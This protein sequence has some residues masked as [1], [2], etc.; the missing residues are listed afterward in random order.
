MIEVSFAGSDRTIIRVVE[1]KVANLYS[2]VATAI[3]QQDVETVSYIVSEELHG[4]VLNQRSGKLAGSI[5]A[6]PAS[7]QGSSII[8]VVEGGGG[9]TGIH[10]SHGD[11]SYADLF[12]HGKPVDIVPINAKALRFET[13]EGEVVYAKKVHLELPRPFMAPAIEFRGPYIGAAVAEAISVELAK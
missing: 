4:Q 6:I 13:I 10:S 12:E 2:V 5:R 7:Q 3:D 1:A 8:G 11:S 9:P